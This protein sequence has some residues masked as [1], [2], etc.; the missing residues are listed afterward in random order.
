MIPFLRTI[1]L[2]ITA[3]FATLFIGLA[4]I[5]AGLFRVKDKPGG[6]YDKAPRW[7]SSAVLWAVGLKVRVHGIENASGGEPHIFA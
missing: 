6:I 3:L 7:W 5:V 1:L 4:V 2:F